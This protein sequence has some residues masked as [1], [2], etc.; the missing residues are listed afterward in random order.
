M[1]MHMI[2]WCRNGKDRRIKRNKNTTLVIIL[3]KEE[4]GGDVSKAQRGQINVS[5]YTTCTCRWFSKN[6]CHCRYNIQTREYY[7]NT[8]NLDGITAVGSEF[9]ERIT[10]NDG[11]NHFFNR[12]HQQRKINKQLIEFC[13][14]SKIERNVSHFR[15][16]VMYF[17]QFLDAYSSQ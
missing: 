1:F 8:C 10:A 16:A 12:T 9:D 2:S 3:K 7:C 17:N 5:C 6:C 13:S 11:T 15:L 4:D 14:L